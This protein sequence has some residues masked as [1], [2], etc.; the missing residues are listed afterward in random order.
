MKAEAELILLPTLKTME[1]RCA[2]L[3]LKP[4]PLFNLQHFLFS[5]A[6]VLNDAFLRQQQSLSCAFL[7][8]NTQKTG[9]AGGGGGGTWDW[10]VSFV[11]PE[12]K[13]IIFFS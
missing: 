3:R 2:I 1:D 7:E 12:I 9:E 5:S 4:P 10:K 6:D 8:A 13:C 11:I